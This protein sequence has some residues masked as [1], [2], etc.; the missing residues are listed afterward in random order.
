MNLKKVIIPFIL[1][2]FISI[3]GCKKEVFNI[4][5]NPNQATDSTVSYDVILASAL[6]STGALI[7]NDW[8]WLQNWLGYWSRS[9]TYAPNVIEESYEITTSFHTE[10]WND[11]YDNL[12]DYDVMQQKAARANAD[13]YEGIARIMKA[14]NYQMLVDVYNNVPYFDALKGNANITPK[15]DK[16]EDIYK[17]LFRQIDTAIDLIN[18]HDPELN[19]NIESYDIMFG[20]DVDLW[21]K[22]GNTL[23]LRMLIHLQ[24]GLSGNNSVPGFDIPGEIAKIDATGVG[25]LGAGEDALVNPGYREDKPNPFYNSYFEDETGAATANSVYYGGNEYAVDYYKYDGDPRLSYFYTA[26]T[27]NYR[28]IKY[29]L[30]SNNANKDGIIAGIGTGLGKGFDQ[31]SWILTAAESFF[32]QAEAQQRGLIPGDAAVSLRQAIIENFR[33]L[34]IEEPEL[35]ADDYLSTNAGYPDVDITAPDGGLFTIL[36]QKYFA[37]NGIA[38]FEVWTDYRRTDIVYGEAVGYDPGPPISVSPQ[39][40]KTEIPIRLLYPQ[41]EYNYNAANVGSQGAI[42]QFNSKIFWDLN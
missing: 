29:G 42:N 24:N 22:F 10:V 2:F 5:S 21:T 35:E 40:T 17:D 18:N 23:K 11:L 4:N 20:G 25:Y 27:E 14:N 30:P 19:K 6:H 7:A 36:S 33:F 28:G 13:F 12:F 38:P 37:F 8:G 34:G 31:P 9:G 1:I 15:Y 32:L 41:N 16:G 3:S 26:G 39:N